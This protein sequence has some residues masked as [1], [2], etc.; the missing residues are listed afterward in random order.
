MIEL[1]YLHKEKLV[2]KF[3]NIMNKT[4][5]KYFFL[6]T[7]Q[8]YER[9]IDDNNWKC[10][11]YVSVKNNKIIG[12][13]KASIDR[14]AHNVDQLYLINFSKDDFF[15]YGKDITSFLKILFEDFCFKKIEFSVVVGNPIEKS[16]DKI[17]EKNGGR[18]VGIFKNSVRLMDGKYYDLK[19]YEVFN[20]NKSLIND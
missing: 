1:A 20:P 9:T 12:Y 10:L 4:R 2:N 8:N 14:I 6:S 11:E 18:I 19:F 5:Y 13:M 7:Y 16:Y 3:K 15:T 17:V